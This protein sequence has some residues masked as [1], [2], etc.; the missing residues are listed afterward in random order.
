MP[1]DN[2]QQLAGDVDDG[3]DDGGWCQ[4]LPLVGSDLL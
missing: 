3:V 2:S 1:N 4:S